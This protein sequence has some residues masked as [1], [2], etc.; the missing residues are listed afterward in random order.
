M[1]VCVYTSVTSEFPMTKSQRRCAQRRTQELLVRKTFA[2]LHHFPRFLSLW[3]PYLL[4]TETNTRQTCC[5]RH[6]RVSSLLLLVLSKKSF[7][8]LRS[9]TTLLP[10]AAVARRTRCKLV[11]SGS[12]QAFTKDM[13]RHRHYTEYRHCLIFFSGAMQVYRLYKVSLGFC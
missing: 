4:G 6:A 3:S 1:C 10:E 5:G 2:S 7:A 8:V 12:Q 13:T 11:V 9:I